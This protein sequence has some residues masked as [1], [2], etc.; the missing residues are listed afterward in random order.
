VVPTVDDTA[1]STGVDRSTELE[2]NP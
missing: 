1:N 2:K